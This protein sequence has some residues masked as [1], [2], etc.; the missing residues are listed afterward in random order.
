MGQIT[1]LLHQ[2][3]LDVTFFYMFV[4]FAGTYF[5]C[6]SLMTKPLGNLLVERDR[7]TLGRQ[8][9]VLKIRVE[10]LEIQEKLSAERQSARAKAG[11]KFSE[12]KTQAV[13]QQRKIVGEARESFAEKVKDA[14]DINEKAVVEERKKIDQL[15]RDLKEDIVHRLLGTTASKKPNLGTE[16]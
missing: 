1:T 11:V 12:L 16:A 5:L 13:T 2:L 9:E 6:A 14:R 8:E 15:S 4:L 10:L 7:R 3:G